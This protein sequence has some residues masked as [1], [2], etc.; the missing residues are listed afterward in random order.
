ML[1]AIKAA[2]MAGQEILKVY[3][4]NFTVE[5][6]V[7]NSPLTEADKAAHNTISGQLSGF[8]IPILSEEGRDIPYEER[9]NWNLFW[10]VDPLDGTKEFVNRNGEFTVNIALIEQDRPVAGIIYAPVTDSLYVGIEEYGAFRINGKK[11]LESNI[12]SLSEL[13]AI[14]E[15]LPVEKASRIYTVLASRSHSNPE[16]EAY[17]KKVAVSHPEVEFLERGSSLKFCSMAEGS[18]DLY[19]R[20]GPTMEWDTAAG[21]AIAIQAGCNVNQFETGLP[22]MYNKQSLL[23]PWFIVSR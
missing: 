17:L 16:T 1:T 10:L 12:R 4:R 13:K 15:L 5:Y 19:P 20:L 14:S 11:Y 6:K 2:Y 18:A 8:G 22:L 9:Q 23:N 21:H 3:S 7:D